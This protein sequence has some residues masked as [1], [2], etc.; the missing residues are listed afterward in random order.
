MKG[1]SHDEEDGDHY[2]NSIKQ[3]QNIKYPNDKP[4]IE[5]EVVSTDT[6]ENGIN[7][8]K[9]DAQNTQKKLAKNTKNDNHESINIRAAIIHV[10]GRFL[11][12]LVLIHLV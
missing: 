6:S 8:N 7:L 1:H 12:V 2:H 5:L 3:L 10:L 9:I 4:H 11:N